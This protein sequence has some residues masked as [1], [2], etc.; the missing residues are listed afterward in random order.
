MTNLKPLKYQSI[1]VLM[2]HGTPDTKP[3]TQYSIQ[4]KKF[5]AQLKYLK[6][7]GWHT[8]LIKDLK[9]PNKLSDKTVL[10]TFDD[11][12]A[13]NYYGAFHPLLEFDMKATWFITSN[14]I[15]KHAHWMGAET[16]ETKILSGLQLK[17]MV[18]QGME[19]ASHTCSHPDLSTLAYS[20]Q[21]E[22]LKQSK[23]TLESI[24]TSEIVSFAY[25]YGR[26][27]QETLMATKQAGYNLACSTRSGFYQSTD[28]PLLIRRVTIFDTDTVSTLARKLVFADNNVSWNHLSRYYWQRLKNRLHL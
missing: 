14:C 18:Q 21:F 5:V 19:I 4:A 28:N 11:G 3:S 27:N 15:D 25:P 24:L 6:K 9:E 8:A 10:L 20:K 1:I 16:N 23:K 17:N 26:Y 13:D 7:N 22:E 2:Y 12:Y